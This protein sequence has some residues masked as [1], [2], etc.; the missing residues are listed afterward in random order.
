M[1]KYIPASFLSITLLTLLIA[2][3]KDSSDE[4]PS[5]P[6][7]TLTVNQSE[8]GTVNSSGGSYQR[9][10][11]VSIS[12]TPNQGYVFT[13]WSNGSTSNPLNI[14]LNSN[15][16]ISPRFEQAIVSRLELSLAQT[17]VMM[18]QET[19]YTYMAYDQNDGPLPDAVP[20]ISISDS[21]FARIENQRIITEYD[22]LLT[23]Y[24]RINEVVDSIQ[25]EIQPDYN[26]WK[27][28]FR[29]IENGI[30]DL[31]DVCNNGG[32]CANTNSVKIDLNNDGRQDLLLHFF[33]DRD[34]LN[35]P[36]DTPVYNRLIAL[37]SN[38]NNQ[39]EN[40]TLDVF[41]NEIVD[42]EGGVSG[43]FKV[44]DINSD[45]YDD[46]VY[47]LH[48]EDGRSLTDLNTWKNFP[49][50][51]I[52]NGDGT[53]QKQRFGQMEINGDVCLIKNVQN[54]IEV[55]LGSNENINNHYLYSGSS[56]NEKS[57]T[58]LNRNGVTMNSYLDPSLDRSSYL[59][60]SKSGTSGLSFYNLNTTVFKIKD[61]EFP[62]TTTVS[63]T[64]WLGNTFTEFPVVEINNYTLIGVTFND[65]EFIR[66]NPNEPPLVLAHLSSNYYNGTVSE[67][68]TITS[69]QT[70]I[71]SKIFA[72]DMSDSEEELELFPN[73]GIHEKNVN[74]IEV[75]DVNNDGFDDVV[76]Y[77]YSYEG[78]PIVYL[79]NTS[80]SFI[81]LANNNIFPSFIEGV[82]TSQFIDVN[83]DGILDI[84]FRYSG[85]SSDY[86]QP[87]LF[88][89]RKP[90]PN[91]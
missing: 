57:S 67:G 77:P 66:V 30:P 75:L 72:F 28:Y 15:I 27:T 44:L 33:K 31:S 18:G 23:I 17:S 87:L 9:G 65:L 51:V 64:T 24:G 29:P 53:Y 32:N 49:V 2:C 12:A 80:G 78:K 6:S 21:L 7:Y 52:S 8:G 82:D 25:L 81:E 62:P 16:E 26:N 14:T 55:I 46:V 54:E 19:N 90:L 20:T 68:Q 47:A 3:S 50:A 10:T 89:G 45:G 58:F 60:Y 5:T 38:E 36:D 39:L 73:K 37:I 83:G 85:T 35:V 42:L 41:G 43:N 22:G 34:V 79:N 86:I 4:T 70:P 40:K 91:Q 13:G 1:K 48:R 76:K 11:E 63:Y 84:V 74:F 59:I 69:D 71:M 88:L 56:F 61:I